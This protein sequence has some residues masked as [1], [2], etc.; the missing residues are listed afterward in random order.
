[1]NNSIDLTKILSRLSSAPKWIKISVSVLA[2]ILCAIALFLCV[3]CGSTAKA[4]IKN[5]AEATTTTVTIT[6]NNPSNIEVS[7]DVSL[8]KPQQK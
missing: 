6:T 3:S 8:S 4:L 7:S 5:N 1:M 2:G